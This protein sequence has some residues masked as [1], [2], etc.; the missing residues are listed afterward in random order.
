MR[1]LVFGSGGFIGQHLI[2]NLQQS[3]EFEVIG[4]STQDGRSMDAA[5]GRI[6][7]DFELPE[8]INTVIYLSQSPYWREGASRF[9][10]VLSVNCG[11]AVKLA[12]LAQRAGAS[13]FIF[14]STGTVYRPSFTPLDE[15][16]DLNR[17]DWYALS[18]LFSEEALLNIGGTMNVSCLRLFGVYGS[19]QQGRLI[20][21]LAK[22]ISTKQPIAL[23]RDLFTGQTE[24]LRSSMTHVDD[25]VA[26]CRQLI[27]R[28][29]LPPIL[30]V[31]SDQVASIR[32][33]A[34]E[35]GRILGLHV[36]FEETNRE[37]SGH[38]VADVTKMQSLVSHT[39]RTLPDGL[40]GMSSPGDLGLV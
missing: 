4:A 11:S 25:L 36:N 6:A 28:E 32:E 30:N 38:F 10:H 14:T 24:G 7:D 23:D 9:D 2:A 27:R 20:S 33:I 15:Q 17:K 16:A 29:Y 34:T 3:G 31:A 39:F 5:A 22:R 40:S 37:L 26:V 13:R 12:S 18:K 35:V 19:K 21:N 1:V 8:N